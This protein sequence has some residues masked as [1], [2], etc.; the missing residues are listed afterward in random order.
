MS[1]ASHS[2]ALCIWAPGLFTG[3]GLP[4]LLRIFLT[5]T[6]TAF[7]LQG[8]QS[9]NISRSILWYSAKFYFT[10]SPFLFH[11]C[12]P[13]CS[14]FSL[15]DQ[16]SRE[17]SILKPDFFFRHPRA[18]FTFILQMQST[19]LFIFDHFEHRI[20]CLANY[21]VHILTGMFPLALSQS[22]SLTSMNKLSVQFLFSHLFLWRKQFS[23]PL[24]G[25]TKH[26]PHQHSQ[27]PL[28]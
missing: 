14:G 3:R 28:S 21:F 15:S 4:Q 2:L 16:K 11:L 20:I 23:F 25:P 8:T 27:R 24:Q 9:C 18:S 6:R 13:A 12:W 5:V 17:F 1:F 7:S 10:F 22:S 26:W 19:R